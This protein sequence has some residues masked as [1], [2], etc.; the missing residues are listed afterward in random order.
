M[1]AQKQRPVIGHVRR[2]DMTNEER[3]AFLNQQRQSQYDLEFLANED[4]S[5]Y[6]A[7]M[8]KQAAEPR[9][10]SMFEFGSLIG[11]DDTYQS[12]NYRRDVVD[13][14]YPEQ[15]YQRDN[16]QN[17]MGGGSRN[18][19]IGP[20]D[21]ILVGG[22]LDALGGWNYLKE[23][24]QRNREAEATVRQ[25]LV[26]EGYNPA[27]TEFWKELQK[28]LPKK[29]GSG[30][31]LFDVAF[32]A[33]EVGIAAKL[34]FKALGNFFKKFIPNAAETKAVGGLSAV[35]EPIAAE[36]NWGELMEPVDET[37][38]TNP[39][40]LLT[41]RETDNL[42]ETLANA[43]FNPDGY[44]FTA[45]DDLLLAQI[46]APDDDISWMRDANEIYNR[47]LNERID[48]ALATRPEYQTPSVI[49]DIEQLRAAGEEPSMI[50]EYLAGVKKEYER[51]FG[52][53]DLISQ[54][55]NTG[56]LRELYEKN[57]LPI[58]KTYAEERAADLIIQSRYTGRVATGEPIDQDM[59]RGIDLDYLEKY[60]TP[61]VFN[62]AKPTIQE[63]LEL[64]RQRGFPNNINNDIGA[65]NNTPVSPRLYSPS[66]RAAEGLPQE[67][68]SYT[69]LKAWMLKNGAK[70]K[71][72]EWT[73]ADEAFEG[74]TNVTKKE[75]VDYLTDNQNLL[76]TDRT[77][78]K[79]VMRGD[80]D[81]RETREAIETYVDDNLY[82]EIRHLEDSFDRGWEYSTESARIADYIAAGDNEVLDEIAKSMRVQ[83]IRNGQDLAESYPDG[84]VG[85]N[86]STKEY[87]VFADRDE[88]MQAD[89]PEFTEEA[90][91]SLREYVDNLEYNDADEFNRILFGDELT[92]DP[93]ELVYAK[94]FPKGG[95]NM[96]E[97]TYQFRDPTGQL[98]DDYFKNP[99][100]F[101]ETGADLNLVAHART[102]EFPVQGGGTAYHVGE[103]QAD[104]AQALREKDKA[105]GEVRKFTPRTR[106][107]EIQI[108]QEEA[109]FYDI[110]D[111]IVT[112]E[113]ILNRSVFGDDVGMSTAWRRSQGEY[114]EQLET[115][116]KVMADFKTKQS[117]AASENGEFV[118]WQPHQIS[119]E[120]TFFDEAKGEMAN[121]RE[122][123]D[124]FSKYIIDLAR[125]VPPALLDTP[126]FSQYKPYIDWAELYTKDIGPK[127]A[128]LQVEH[129]KIKKPDYENTKTGAPFIESTD[130]WVGMLLKRQL[131]EAIESGANFMT[132]PNP[133]MVKKYTYGE[134][135][136]HR[137]FYGDIATSNLLDIAKS[138]DPD[139][140]LVGKLIETDAGPEPVSALPLTQKLIDAIMEKGISTYAVPL[141]VGAGSGY[142]ALN[143]VGGQDGRSGS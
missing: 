103:G 57:G 12:G 34:S 142:G 43:D 63:T 87:T 65:L 128:Y 136:G 134:Y 126:E 15:S 46:N 18:L 73:G 99:E 22:P 68:G 83:N 30:E 27:S 86:R 5:L 33:F 78:A 9:P 97:T 121:M 39:E 28:R 92:A 69:Q 104:I 29:E 143:Q 31:A 3:E 64:E 13:Y 44:T 94:Y 48:T 36:P 138:Y 26:D 41:A 132:L 7:V 96:S 119:D 35:E 130:A 16:A 107:E 77:T 38:I 89:M 125:D 70:A 140:T 75:L 19:G 110:R 56:Q 1:Q 101:E 80:T 4:P 47:R 66:V 61:D 93:S 91:Q 90:R 81:G 137:T 52:Q 14:F 17:I 54:A 21:L 74:R 72:M 111:Q 112:A 95:T 133:K 141:A 106:E 135:E 109:L 102:A 123:L 113:D 58:P 118:I 114:A 32:G 129:A 51:D 20:A 45:E 79:G 76:F 100:H 40:V 85:Y 115:F 53:I 127:I 49:R 11:L 116:K 2:G 55:R 117:Q 120:A 84:W 82:N 67:K 139:A 122:N 50:E 71:E 60:A 23:M 108:P 124:A 8:D 59:R 42:D 62:K 25:T 37:P 98:P 131:K 24:S 6:K 10:P 88:A 105:T